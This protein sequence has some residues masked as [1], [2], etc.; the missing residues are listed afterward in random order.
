MAT[1]IIAKDEKDFGIKEGVLKVGVLKRIRNVLGGVEGSDRQ[2]SETLPEWAF[3]SSNKRTAT[4]VARELTEQG[5][6]TRLDPSEVP[7]STKQDYYL[8]TEK[9]FDLPPVPIGTEDAWVFMRKNKPDYGNYPGWFR[10]SDQLSL[11]QLL[12]IYFNPEEVE[13]L[14]YD[15]Q[16]GGLIGRHLKAYDEYSMAEHIVRKDRLK[17]TSANFLNFLA[18][19]ANRD[20]E[21]VHRAVHP[22]IN[23]PEGG[24]PELSSDQNRHIRE[25]I[26]SY[27]STGSLRMGGITLHTDATFENLSGDLMLYRNLL[28]EKASKILE[29]VAEVDQIMKALE[30]A[31]GEFAE[32]FDH[33]VNTWIE[34]KGEENEDDE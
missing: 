17:M 13:L 3:S 25:T 12:W 23:Y 10:V 16:L 22:L 6:F 5:F 26:G 19:Y 30:E 1:A 15:G 18:Y 2:R 33:Q 31:D 4:R 8:L 11:G 20:K 29:Q 24:H 34:N 32:E 21:D 28:D 27:G 9:V 14:D 7:H